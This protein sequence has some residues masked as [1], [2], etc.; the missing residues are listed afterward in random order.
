MKHPVKLLLL[1]DSEVDADLLLAYLRQHELQVEAV[2]VETEEGFRQALDVETWDLI[3]SDFNLS[4]FDGMTALRILR[5]KDL[6]LPFILISGAL[7]EESA[8]EAIR[9]GANDFVLKSNLARLKPVMDRELRER[10]VR[11]QARADQN[12]LRLLQLAVRQ[13]PDSLVITDPEGVIIYVNPSMESVSGYSKEELLGQNPRL[14]K[15]GRHDA[16]FYQSLWDTLLRGEVW[17][18]IFVNRRKDGLYWECQAVIAPVLGADGR[19]AYYEYTSRDVTHERDLQS[20]LE[21]A[22]RLEAIGVLTGGIAHDFN[23][24]LMPIMGNAEVGAAR[25]GGSPQV[26]HHFEVIQQCAHRAADLIK[27]ILA[28]S[29]KS[30]PA[31]GP[32]DLSQLVKES[33]KLMRATLPSSIDLTSELDPDGGRVVGDPT[34]LH[35]IVMNLCTNAAHAMHGLPGR[36]RVGLDRWEAIEETLC[37][38]G[39]RLPRGTYLRLTVSDSGCGIAPSTL[40]QIFLPFFTT[41]APGEGTGLGLSIVHG[42]IQGMGGGIQVRSALGEGTEFQIYLPVTQER[43]PEEPPQSTALPASFA[44]LLVV[45]DEFC[46][47]DVMEPGLASSGF[48]VTRFADPTEALAAFRAT[49]MNFDLLLSDLTMPRMSGLELACEVGLVR[50][51]FPIILMTG[52]PSRFDLDLAQ[53]LNIKEVIIKPALPSR[54]ARSINAAL[55]GVERPDFT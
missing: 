54:V 44:R 49:P 22:Q 55:L 41:K 2:R 33:L 40:D 10:D 42:I 9:H 45:D 39:R 12:E 31:S 27:Q 32:V 17:R 38:A 4:G 35:Q 46:I 36:L 20:R 29:R 37:T 1:E 53:R 23:N 47:L 25:S 26:L 51:G 52:H 34:Q 28:F 30:E 19:A 6:D 8:V 11:R 15:S 3:I 43:E 14:L 50:P 5:A 24:I 16:A 21:Q 18:G 7:T 48:T 13:M